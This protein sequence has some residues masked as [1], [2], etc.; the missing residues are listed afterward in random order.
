MDPF[1]RKMILAA[2]GFASAMLLMAG[3]LSAVYFHLHPQCTEQVL[4][5]A[6]SPD[7]KW[8]AS[9]MERR[10]GDEAPFLLHINLRPADQAI[11]FGYF[12]GNASEGE[13]FLA[14]EDTRAETPD[15]KWSSSD[16]L[17][18]RCAHCSARFAR[19]MT[20]RW[21]SLDIQYESVP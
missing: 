9:A 20:E 12:S 13:V 2:L 1:A 7:K 5:E 18:I 4:A 17:H 16:Q 19:A 15:L 8:I 11:R 21:Q 10:C 3:A 6:I 14:E